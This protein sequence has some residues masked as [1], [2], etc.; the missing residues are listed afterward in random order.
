MTR[1][2]FVWM[3][4]VGIAAATWLVAWGARSRDRDPESLE[5]R[6]FITCAVAAGILVGLWGISL[7]NALPSLIREAW[8]SPHDPLA[9]EFA[10]PALVV[11]LNALLVFGSRSS[12]RVATAS[13]LIFL[14]LFTIFSGIGLIGGCIASGMDNDARAMILPVMAGCA[15]MAGVQWICLRAV[16]RRSAVMGAAA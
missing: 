16:R 3:F 5:R 15:L 4:L 1:A 6:A 10:L 7:A 14:L 11:G 12:Q 9:R 8:D 2:T 13:Q